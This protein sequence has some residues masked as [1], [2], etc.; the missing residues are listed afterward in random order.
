MRYAKL[1]RCWALIS[2]FLGAGD[3]FSDLPIMWS[4]ALGACQE[5][6]FI[7][8]AGAQCC[9]S[10]SQCAPRHGG[11]G[12]NCG[13]PFKSRKRGTLSLAPTLIPSM[14]VTYPC[15]VISLSNRTQS[16]S[17]APHA[18]GG[19]LRDSQQLPWSPLK[20]NILSVLCCTSCRKTRLKKPSLLFSRSE[21]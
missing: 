14:A 9:A 13:I 2:V 8:S 21:I 3:Y 15:F 20:P 5:S 4:C 1:N 16:L 19:G 11:D 17:L 10:S 18:N 12:E 6:S 7:S